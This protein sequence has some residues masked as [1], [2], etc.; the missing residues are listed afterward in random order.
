MVLSERLYDKRMLIIDITQIMRKLSN[1]I[2]QRS[3]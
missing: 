3:E 1:K 2:P